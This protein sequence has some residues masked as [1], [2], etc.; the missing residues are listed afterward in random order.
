MKKRLNK[1]FDCRGKVAVVTGGAGLIGSAVTKGLVAHGARV[2]VAESDS[3]R[4]RAGASKSGALPLVMDITT[5]NSIEVAL[6]DVA[7]R[8]GIDILVNCAYPRTSDWGQVLEKVRPDSFHRNVDDHLGGYFFASRAA[9]EIM[10][11][12]HSGSIINFASIYGI[13]APDF[14]LYKGTSL[15][16]PPAY[17]A[18]KGGIIAFTKY[19]ATYYAPYGIRANV[20]SPGGVENGQP[21]AFVR[22]YSQKTP[23]GRMAR[24]EDLVGAVIYLASDAS[25]YVTGTNLLV[26]GGWTAW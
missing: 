25:S 1:I 11:R 15:T 9:A 8:V 2:F 7:R 16:M 12:H 20:V 17:S 10:K 5:P 4:A 13:S 24:P 14:G 3:R 19:L 18:I 26:D 21:S 6:R 22:R 23:L